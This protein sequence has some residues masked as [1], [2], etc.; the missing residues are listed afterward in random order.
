MGPM[1][2]FPGYLVVMAAAAAVGLLAC[3]GTSSETPWPVEPESRPLGPSGETAPPAAEVPSAEPGPA[4]PHTSEQADAG[5]AR[6]RPRAPE[7][8]VDP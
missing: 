5:V 3:G 1:R 6:K 2:L 7:P 8:N 4:E